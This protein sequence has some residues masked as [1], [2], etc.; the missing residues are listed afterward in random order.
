[1]ATDKQQAG[2]DPSSQPAINLRSDSVERTIALG[3]IIAKLLQPGDVIALEGELGAGK[4]QFVRG[5]AAGMGLDEE[6]V[7]SP[8]F[9]LMHE[10]LPDDEDAPALVH[11]D[12]YRLEG[13]GDLATL[14][15]DE[16]GS[17]PGELADNAVVVVEWASRIADD[18]PADALFIEITHEDESSRQVE[19]CVRNGWEARWQAFLSRFV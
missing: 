8:T 10:Y 5:L 4:T 7:S 1:M 15:W 3:S 9:V 11:I 14:G 12:A 19:I 16:G 13:S 2:G 17:G 6:A 18:L